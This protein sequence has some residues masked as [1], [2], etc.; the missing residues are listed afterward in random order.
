M[1]IISKMAKPK[2]E[3]TFPLLAE[4]WAREG[5]IDKQI[6]KNL[7]ISL[8]AFYKYQNEHLEFMEAIKRGKAPV[9]VEVE[10]ALLE[11]AK[12]FDY[13]ETQIEF[14][15]KEADEKEAKPMKIKKIT[16][17]VLADPVSI[18]FWLKNRKPKKWRDRHEMAVGGSEELPPIA[19]VPCKAAK[20]SMAKAGEKNG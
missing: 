18:I 15:P 10:N 14:K 19:V 20:D 5:L 16:K 8:A 4:G 12:G 2:Y 3:D 11:R 7:G 9:D 6:A 13:E 17:K 1:S